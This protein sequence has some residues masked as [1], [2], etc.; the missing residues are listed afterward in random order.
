MVDGYFNGREFA[1]VF[2]ASIDILIFSVFNL[3]VSE[4]FAIG[5]KLKNESDLTI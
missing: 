2:D 1:E 3:I 5:L 4:V